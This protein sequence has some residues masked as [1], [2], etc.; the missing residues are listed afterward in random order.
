MT[1]GKNNPNASEITAANVGY[2][3]RLWQMADALRGSM[4]AA[5]YKHVVFG[6]I[7]LKYISDAFEGQH[8]RLEAQRAEGADPRPRRLPRS[9]S[10]PISTRTAGRHG[11]TAQ[12]VEPY[13]DD[14]RERCSQFSQRPNVRG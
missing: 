12:P 10:C 5:E 7:L 11:R 6:L 3:A 2:E 1:R 14:P 8:A 4:D 9:G 13:W